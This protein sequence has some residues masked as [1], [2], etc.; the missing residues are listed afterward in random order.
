MLRSESLELEE[1][2]LRSESLELEELVLR[3]ESL[4]LEEPESLEPDVEVW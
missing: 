3:S 1:P 4:E 2:V